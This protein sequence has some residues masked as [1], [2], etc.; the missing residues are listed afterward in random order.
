MFPK[1]IKGSVEIDRHLG[2]QAA[3]V[4][5]DP[6]EDS[7]CGDGARKLSKAARRAGH[8]VERDQVA[9]HMRAA[10]ITGSPPRQEGT[11]HQTRPHRG[12]AS[13]GVK[14]NST[15]TAPIQL[16]VAD[17]PF[18]PTRAGVA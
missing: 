4:V 3:A 2:R 6:V 15:A 7:C 12:A 14:R 16:R 5:L 8:V 18:V 13:R 1:P 11:H 17:L 10:V 9:R